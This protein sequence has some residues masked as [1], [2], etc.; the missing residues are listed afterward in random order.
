MSERA[1]RNHTGLE[2]RS[3]ATLR[4]FVASFDMDA[5]RPPIRA[6]AK[7]LLTEDIAPLRDKRATGLELPS[8]TIWLCHRKSFM[9]TGPGSAAI[10]L[11]DVRPRPRA[12]AIASM[13]RKSVS[14]REP[15]EE[16]VG[17][18]GDALFYLGI[19]PRFQVPGLVVPQLY[20]C[21][22]GDGR[23]TMV[24]EYLEPAAVQPSG[25]ERVDRS[26]GMVGRLGGITYAQRLHELDWIRPV[27]P[28]LPPETLLMLER[29]AASCIADAGERSNIVAAV[30]RLMSSPDVLG[31]IRADAYPCLAHGDLHVRNV[32]AWAGNDRDLAV[33]DWGKMSRGFIG[34]DAVLLLLP[35]YIASGEWGD[36]SFPGA[37]RRVQNEVI[38]GAMSVAAGLDPARIRLGLDLGL[39]FQTAVLA[40]R[41]AVE[42]TGGNAGGAHLRRRGRI[43]SV[44]R[45]VADCCESLLRQYA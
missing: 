31:R 2:A 25:L 21:R 41:N 33:I 32:F 7:L 35:R 36:T 10:D 27:T 16:Q 39:V 22:A 8:R 3:L 37:A 13:V 43:A 1:S 26:A 15:G 6:A 18:L 38:A 28:R 4:D 11:F 29:L 5:L 9:P 20:G 34:Q 42:W 40:A 45:H 24:I 23:V 19:A 17:W 44:F 12:P 14:K 30:E